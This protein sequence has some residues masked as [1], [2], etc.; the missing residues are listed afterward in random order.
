MSRRWVLLLVTAPLLAIAVGATLILKFA[1]VPETPPATIGQASISGSIAPAPA[2]P[3]EKPTTAPDLAAVEL[4][5]LRGQ[6]E[7][8]RR[9]TAALR[10]SNQKL[11]A[12]QTVAA[13]KQSPL[14][15]SAQPPQPTIDGF[16][17]FAKTFVPLQQESQQRL[18]TPFS[19]RSFKID[20]K[21]LSADVKKTD[22]LTNPIVGVVVIESSDTSIGA[23]GSIMSIRGDIDTITFAPD[24]GKWKPIA[25]VRKF[26]SAE[27][28]IDTPPGAETTISPDMATAAAEAAQR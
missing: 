1:H 11:Q 28:P 2:I 16:N 10:A 7:A 17:A 15:P 23:D 5:A 9:E 4:A 3:T 8:L 21:L 12:A 20:C 13:E 27:P 6:V 22:S 19:D 24:N 26:D 18:A 14:G 25:F